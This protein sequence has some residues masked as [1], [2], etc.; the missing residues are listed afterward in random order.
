MISSSASALASAFGGSREA[1]FI[2]G[3]EVSHS[4]KLVP[5]L[6]SRAETWLEFTPLTG[7]SVELFSHELI[8]GPGSHLEHP[9]GLERSTLMNPSQRGSFWMSPSQRGSFFLMDMGTT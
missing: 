9:G 8:N 3:A 1:I 4:L 5:R 2:F 6:A 7:N